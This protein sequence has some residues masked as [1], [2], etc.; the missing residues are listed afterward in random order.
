MVT[1]RKCTENYQ[2][3]AFL[4]IVSL[5][6]RFRDDKVIYADRDERIT[7]DDQNTL[8]INIEVSINFASRFNDE[9][10]KVEYM[11]MHHDDGVPVVKGREAKC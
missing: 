4:I 10:Y 1:F 11:V 8:R 3:T 2:E 9:V 7:I 6:F 5:I